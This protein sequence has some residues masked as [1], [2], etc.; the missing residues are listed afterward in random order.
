MYD[1][2]VEDRLEAEIAAIQEEKLAVLAKIRAMPTGIISS[3]MN[4]PK[5]KIKCLNMFFTLDKK[6]Q[7][8][9]KELFILIKSLDYE[10]DE[11]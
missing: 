5:E 11:E 3:K 8:L 1:P 10:R 6:Q 4:T 2:L 7:G 9:E